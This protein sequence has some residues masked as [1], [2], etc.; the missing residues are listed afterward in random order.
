M[1][2]ALLPFRMALAATPAAA[3]T[4]SDL[5]GQRLVGADVQE[6]AAVDA[7]LG[8]ADLM[9]LSAD[10]GILEPGHFADLVAVQGNPLDDVRVL[11]SV[12]FVLHN[13]VVVR[14]DVAPS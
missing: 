5:L 2:R 8:A 13:G 9:G 14:N 1:R 4:G 7:T 10:V 12:Q 3:Q 11:E 6:L